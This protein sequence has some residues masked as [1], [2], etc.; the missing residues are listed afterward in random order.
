MKVLETQ[1][2]VLR[3]LTAEDGEF[4]LELLNDPA[5]LRYIGDKGVRTLDAARDYILN[6]PA[7]MYEQFG[8]GLYLVELKDGSVPIGIC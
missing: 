8:F 7:A 6:G 5:W 1:R 2:L 3:R 4:I